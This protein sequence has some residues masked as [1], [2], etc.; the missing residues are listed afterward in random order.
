MFLVYGDNDTTYAVNL[1]SISKFSV[2]GT[3]ISDYSVGTTFFRADTEK[4]ALNAFNDIIEAAT[5]GLNVY[6]LRKEVGYWKAK[7]PGPKPKAKAP[8]PENPQSTK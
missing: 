6:D 5:D 4:E 3:S 7:K 8:A 2:S 1:G